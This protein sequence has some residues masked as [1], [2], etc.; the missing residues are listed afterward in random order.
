MSLRKV[1]KFAQ[2][3][4]KGQVDLAGEPY[5]NH[6]SRVASRL[7][8]SL[9]PIAYLHDIFEDTDTVV[10]DLERLGI[11]MRTIDT[12]VLLTRME[13]EDYTDYIERIKSN[14]FAKLVKVADLEDN[15]NICRLKEL[16]FRD[17]QRLR[18]YHKAYIYLKS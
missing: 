5:F 16:T 13:G 9:R 8:R 11:N 1:I 18:K 14:P 4:H 17:L 7:P 6:L 3:K 12:I 10:N 2:E 15:M